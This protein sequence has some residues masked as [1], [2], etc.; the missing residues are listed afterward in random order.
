MYT[1][2]VVIYSYILYIL[3][4]WLHAHS[5]DSPGCIPLWFALGILYCGWAIHGQ[6]SP[7]LRQKLTIDW[8][9]A[10]DYQK[11]KS[12]HGSPS[13]HL[14]F[15]GTVS[16]ADIFHCTHPPVHEIKHIHLHQNI[17]NEVSVMLNYSW[18]P[19][20]VSVQWK[21]FSTLGDITAISDIVPILN[22][23]NQR[24]ILQSGD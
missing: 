10:T 17:C 11:W 1:S 2:H 16:L 9:S 13:T 18:V 6:A 14:L 22:G 4:W 24:P 8:L 21:E 5:W 15:L 20:V 12:L 7:V 23:W 3:I 19:S